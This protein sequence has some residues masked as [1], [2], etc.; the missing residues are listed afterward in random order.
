[1]V[2]TIEKRYPHR[3]GSPDDRHRAPAPASAALCIFPLT[4]VQLHHMSAVA[5]ADSAESR[6]MTCQ[7]R[8]AGSLEHRIHRSATRKENW[9]KRERLGAVDRCQR[10]TPASIVVRRTS[11]VDRSDGRQMASALPHHVQHE[12]GRL[13]HGHRIRAVE[14]NMPRG[15]AEGAQLRGTIKPA[16]A[17]HPTAYHTELRVGFLTL[18]PPI[19]NWPCVQQYAP[20]TLACP[21]R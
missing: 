20:V 8:A 19:P 4:T 15:L 10:V 14:A 9:K 16:A 3:S 18:A 17:A 5:P 6:L 1:M 7:Q 21:P 13:N 12:L 11:G 2:H